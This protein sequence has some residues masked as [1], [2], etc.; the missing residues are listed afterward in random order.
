MVL[1]ARCTMTRHGRSRGWGGADDGIPQLIL[2]VHR[3]QKAIAAFGKSFNKAWV[4]SG[5]SEDLAKLVDDGIQTVIKIYKGVVRPQC[6]PEFFAAYDA[7]GPVKKNKEHMKGLV[8]QAQADARFAQFPAG[9]INLKDAEAENFRRV[10][11]RH[12]TTS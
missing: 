11:S 2:R 7:A 10:R 5:I 9:Y 3:E 8:L 6:L 1:F 4:G 12:G